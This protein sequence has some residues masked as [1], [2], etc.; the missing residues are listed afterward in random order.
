MVRPAV[1]AALQGVQLLAIDS[2]PLIYFIERHPQFG[3]PMSEVG[4]RLDSGRLRAVAATLTLTEVLTQPLRLNRQ[5]VAAAYRRIL[6]QHAAVRLVDL[7]PTIAALAAEL[8]ARHGLKTPD[9]VQLATAI[10]AGCD[11]FLTNDTGL[12]RV[13]EI[14]VIQLAGLSGA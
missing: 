3:P 7:D 13:T 2:A 14:R 5:D 9:A 10:A 4:A 8:R 6:E 12:S 11:A 1:K